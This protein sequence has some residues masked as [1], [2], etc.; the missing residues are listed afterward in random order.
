MNSNYKWINIAITIVI[1]V[2]ITYFPIDS[3][4]HKS[5]FVLSILFHSTNIYFGPE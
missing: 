5:V 4:K 3:Y 1:P 2:F